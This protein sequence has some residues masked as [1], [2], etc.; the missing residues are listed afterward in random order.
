ML[1]SLLSDSQARRS[2]YFGEGTGNIFLDG[3]TCTGTEMRLAD[4]PSNQ[5]GGQNC[6]H[7]QDAGV[8]CQPRGQF[9]PNLQ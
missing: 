7:S 9:I 2:A 6:A 8:Q 4:C 3:L 5:L 1:F